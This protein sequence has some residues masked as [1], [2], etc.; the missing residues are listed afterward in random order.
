MTKKNTENPLYA[1]DTIEFVTVAAQFC[2]YLEQCQEKSRREFVETM[3]KLLPLLYMKATLVPR[4]ESYGNFLPAEQVTE[5]DYNC[6]RTNVACIMGND[7]EY[8]ELMHGPDA[9]PEEIVWQSVS[10]GLA[11]IYQ[12]LRNFVF[13]YQQRIDDCMTDALWIVM[14]HFE[15]FW[16]QCLVDT[17]RRLHVVRYSQPALDDEDDI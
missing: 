17:L 6:I 1:H 9:E 11:D 2:V 7:D 4:I 15:L 14:D 13:A 5:D 3:I 12:P 16:G 10:E 8:E